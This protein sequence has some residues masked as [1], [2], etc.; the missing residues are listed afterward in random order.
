MAATKLFPGRAIRDAPRLLDTSEALETKRRGVNTNP[1]TRIGSGWVS[2]DWNMDRKTASLVF[3]VLEYLPSAVAA[4]PLQMLPVGEVSGQQAVLE[5]DARVDKGRSPTVVVHKEGLKEA[6]EI[7]AH[8]FGM[9]EIWIWVLV[10]SRGGK[11]YFSLR[12]GLQ[13]PASRQF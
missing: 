9:F 3:T 4:Q 8:H 13:L 12:V 10:S 7:S 5:G 6:N 2:E 1:E 11:G